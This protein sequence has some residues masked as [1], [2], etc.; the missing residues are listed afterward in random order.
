ME[1]EGK[2]QRLTRF[3]VEVLDISEINLQ[4]KFLLWH[5]DV[6]FPSTCKASSNTV[7]PLPPF[8]KKQES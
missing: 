1:Y 2:K 6:L 4:L 8:F 7:F 3:N 5:V